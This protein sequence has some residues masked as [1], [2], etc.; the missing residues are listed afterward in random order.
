MIVMTCYLLSAVIT[1]GNCSPPV[2]LFT[3][4]ECHA[5]L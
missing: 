4:G 5:P 1:T 3:D 2:Y